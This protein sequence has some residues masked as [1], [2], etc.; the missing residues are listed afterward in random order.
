MPLMSLATVL[1][2][3]SKLLEAGKRLAIVLIQGPFQHEQRGCLSLRFALSTA[4]GVS[5]LDC[6]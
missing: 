1:Q 2:L 5:A 3:P 6:G 4:C